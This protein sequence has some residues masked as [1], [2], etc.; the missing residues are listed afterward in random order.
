[1]P[2]EQLDVYELRQ[3]GRPGAIASLIT[4]PRHQV[5][6]LRK[7]LGLASATGGQRRC[8]VSAIVAHLY[9]AEPSPAPVLPAVQER[10]F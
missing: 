6:A 10:L 5:Q 1:M 9:P 3:L 8:E 7:R 4:W 2:D